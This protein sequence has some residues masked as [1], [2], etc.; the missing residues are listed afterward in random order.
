MGRRIATARE[1]AGMTQA[2]LASAISLDRS[3]LAKIEN[4]SR[5][6]SALELAR[7][8]EA[9]GERIEWFVMETPV[10]IVS[11]RN[12]GE[13]TAESPEID[14]LIE[15]IAYNVEFVTGHDDRFSLSS[16]EPV[17]RPGTPV[18]AERAAVDARRLLGIG[19]V[20]PLFNLSARFSAL[21]LLSFSFDLGPNSADA[22]SILLES[23]GVAVVNGH[24][25]VG[26]RRL[27]LAHEFGHYLFADEYAVDWRISES[28]D[29]AAWESRIDRFARALLLPAEGLERVWTELRRGGDSLRTASVK[30]ASRFRVDMATLAHRLRELKLVGEGE[31][32]Q[33]RAYR[34]VRADIVELNLVTSDELFS[35]HLVRAYEE[36][37]LRL[38]RQEVISGARAVDL[39]FDTWDEGD[40]PELSVLPES[41]I[42]DFV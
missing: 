36:S 35:P 18:E 29:D 11:H 20:D 21:G 7:M 8:A 26:R 5:R 12:T 6:V 2:G 25:R 9:L 15:R 40:L 27:A 42:W 30:T 16:L 3:A 24:V 14:R 19:N 33:I 34:T 1:R 4:G 28:D 38:Y 22:A 17:P 32:L 23:G 37:V 10:A 13:S 31:R 41:A 39:L